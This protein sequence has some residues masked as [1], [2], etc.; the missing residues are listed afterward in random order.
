MRRLVFLLLL[1]LA[2]SLAFAQA[3][4]A[5]TVVTTTNTGADSLHVG[6]AVGSSSC[7]GGIKAGSLTATAITINTGGAGLVIASQI[8][9]VTTN[10]LYNNSGNLYFNGVALATGSSVSGTSNKVA[11]FTGSST[12]GNSSLSDDGST[13]STTLPL[14]AASLTVNSVG[15]V[16][17][18]GKIPAISSTYFTSLSG[19]NLTGIPTSAVSSGNYVASMTGGTNI[20]VSSGSGNASTPVVSLPLALTGSFSITGTFGVGTASPT[21]QMQVVKSIAETSNL[22]I[23]STEVLKLSNS[24]NATGD[25]ALIRFSGPANDTSVLLGSRL[26]SNSTGDSAFV[27][28]VRTAAGAVVENLHLDSTGALVVTGTMTA[29]SG[30]F[31]HSRSVAMGA[32]QNQSY[33][34][35]DY[36]TS[37]SG[38]FTVDAGDVK[39]NSYRLV[40]DTL[41]W[42]V[43]LES[44][45][46][47]TSDGFLVTI[48]GGY[49]A[50]QESCGFGYLVDSS[51]NK[52]IFACAGVSGTTVLIRGVPAS[53]FT[54]VTEMHF[55]IHLKIS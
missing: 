22:S 55:Q 20:T 30:I 26:V 12:I 43:D 11:K 13:V 51:V 28:G 46:G 41:W 21:S 23:A 14:T 53:V 4:G 32:S 33:N 31:E 18:T 1:L 45:A 49:T 24:H 52:S 39:N 29:A 38:S 44:T 17:T 2:P 37:V 9:A 36:S 35:G 8:P 48:P 19:A 50:A 54:S 3:P 10:A 5:F 16:G 15:I 40:G 27:V 47:S 6:C 7:T 34:A 25:Y 42:S